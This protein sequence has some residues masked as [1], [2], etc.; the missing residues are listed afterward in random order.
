MKPAVVFWWLLGQ[1]Y[2][3][4]G[5]TSECVSVLTG[6]DKLGLIKVRASPVDLYAISE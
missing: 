2:L 4:S 1:K 3:Q 6:P 5:D